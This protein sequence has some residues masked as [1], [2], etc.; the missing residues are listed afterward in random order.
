VAAAASRRDSKVGASRGSVGV[1]YS[2]W[3]RDGRDE[4]GSAGLQRAKGFELGAKR[5]SRNNNNNK[6]TLSIVSGRL[7][8]ARRRLAKRSPGPDS[9]CKG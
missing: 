3:A 9:A 8:V 1:Q 2:L 4:R 7:C 5:R 6:C